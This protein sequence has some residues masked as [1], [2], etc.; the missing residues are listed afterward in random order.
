MTVLRTQS[1]ADTP[2]ERFN[3]IVIPDLLS[4][5]G[6]ARDLGDDGLSRLK[7]WVQDGGTLVVIGGAVDFAR[8]DL[9]MLSLGNW[10]ES[11]KKGTNGEEETE[12]EPQRFHVP[13]AFVRTT[14]DGHHWMAAGY[15][16]DLPVLVNS[17]RLLEA[18]KGP[19]RSGRRVIA[20]Y[21]EGGSLLMSGH[22]WSESLERLP[23]KVFAYEEIVGNG[24][25]IAFAEDVNF[26][27]YWRGVDRLFLN[28]VLIG[29]SAP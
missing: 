17:S 25:I 2:I 8:D 22:A 14:L 6:F 10:Y 4:H 9:E 28:A 18:P 19:P 11:E 29:P 20:R 3:V 5:E 27:G 15:D 24:R 23:G 12:E 13:G 7:R 16:G 21:S 26:R 1:I